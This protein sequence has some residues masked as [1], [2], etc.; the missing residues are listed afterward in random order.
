[1][2]TEN[3]ATITRISIPSASRSRN[4]LSLSPSDPEPSLLARLHGPEAVFA[5]VNTQPRT[6][7]SQ[8]FD[9][10]S[11]V[12]DGEAEQHLHFDPVPSRALVD[13]ATE[14]DPGSAVAVEREFGFGPI[15]A[16]DGGGRWGYAGSN[17]GFRSEKGWLRGV[18]TV[19]Q[20]SL[21]PEGVYW[22]LPLWPRVPVSFIH[23]RYRTGYHHRL[24]FWDLVIQNVRVFVLGLAD[25]ID[26]DV[27]TEGFCIA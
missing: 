12:D 7:V 9:F 18:R 26:R 14:R 4:N 2:S 11:S 22:M 5:H 25:D 6:S 10:K 27:S 1:M 23:M 16:G 8:E 3:G 17:V 19:G 21:G 15:R 24:T 20:E 13:A